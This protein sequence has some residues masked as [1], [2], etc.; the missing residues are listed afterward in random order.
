MSS[1][2]YNSALKMLVRREHSAHELCQK[3]K[4]KEF[5]E[6][7]I[8]Q[9]LSALQQQNYQSDER[10]CQSII[11]TRIRQ[12]KGRR[13]IIQELEQH[14]IHNVDIESLSDGVDFFELCQQVKVKKFGEKKYAS[15][16]EKSKQV[17]LLQSR[18]FSFDEIMHAIEHSVS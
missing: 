17:R 12:G 4:R 9:A 14:Q 15:I 5:S 2:C 13:I 7:E 11:N 16:Q 1:A 18:G 6:A 3:L 8:N 10:F